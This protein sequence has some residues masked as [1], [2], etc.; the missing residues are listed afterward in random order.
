MGMYEARDMGLLMRMAN[1]AVASSGC[2]MPD[3][4]PAQRV[5]QR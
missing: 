1:Y 3:P 4:L 5:R 2:T